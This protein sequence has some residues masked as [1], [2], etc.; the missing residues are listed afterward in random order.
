MTRWWND[1]VIN[2]FFDVYNPNNLETK[3]SKGTSISNV[4]TY[5]STGVYAILSDLKA[6]PCC[7]GNVV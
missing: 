5:L 3:H 6:Y 2:A 1:N 4:T 7:G